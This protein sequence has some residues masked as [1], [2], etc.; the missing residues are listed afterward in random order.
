MVCASAEPV[1]RTLKKTGMVGLS[2]SQASSRPAVITS[3]R[4]N[5]PQKFTRRHLTLGLSSTSS[6]AGLALVYAAPPISKKVRRPPAVVRDDVHGGHGEPGTV[7]EHADV[8]V[9]FDVPQPEG[10]PPRLQ[11]C[12]RLWAPSAGELLTALD[13][14]IVEHELAVERDQPPVRKPGQRIHLEQ[15]GV[16]LAVGAIERG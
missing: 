9:E 3:V 7:G 2:A 8:A 6:N 16:V 5:A 4:A 14:G 1:P 11:H 10:L 15:L 12:E 13:P